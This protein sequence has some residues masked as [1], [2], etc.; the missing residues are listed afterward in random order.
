[1][2]NGQ[3]TIDILEMAESSKQVNST[4]QYA[5]ATVHSNNQ[6][7]TMNPAIGFSGLWDYF[8]ILN[9]AFDG[10]W[11]G[12]PGNTTVWSQQ[13]VFDWVRVYQKKKKFR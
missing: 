9:I 5:H 13:M 8:M 1:V 7:N 10:K 6:S 12:Q 3:L 4:D 2:Q 11:P